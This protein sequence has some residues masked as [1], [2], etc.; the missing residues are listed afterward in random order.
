MSGRGDSTLCSAAARRARVVIA[1]ACVVFALAAAAATAQLV[2]AERVLPKP[3]PLGELA[4]YPSG[5]WLTQS[6]MGDATAWAD[7]LW[8]RAV[9][10]YGQHR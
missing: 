10:Y 1:R 2:A 6:A 4:Y 7:L 3:E 9:Q 8:L 5:T